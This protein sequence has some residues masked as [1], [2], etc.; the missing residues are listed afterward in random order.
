MLSK[1]INAIGAVV[2]VLVLLAIL[3]G[4]AT[5]DKR[6]TSIESTLDKMERQIL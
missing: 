1:L 4:I 3:G 6:L 2:T 5:V